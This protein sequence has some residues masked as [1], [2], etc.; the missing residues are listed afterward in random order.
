MK[1][2]FVLLFAVL[3][4]SC[5]TIT[6]GSDPVVVRAQ[7]VL[8]NSLSVYE[9]AM[10]THYAIST[11]EPPAVYHATEQVRVVFPKAWRGLRAAIDAY[12]ASGSKDPEKLRL[13]VLSFFGEAEQIGPDSWR[14]AIRLIRK[15]FEGA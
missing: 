3:L 13:A 11:Q 4:T 12:K 2:L 5:A 10:K 1:R 15:A 14:D 9:A 7:D 8:T 6:P